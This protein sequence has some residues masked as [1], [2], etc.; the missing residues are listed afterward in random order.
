MKLGFCSQLLHKTWQLAAQSLLKA[1]FSLLS[2]PL[3]LHA[4][5]A[6]DPREES[7]QENG[8]TR[9]SFQCQHPPSWGLAFREKR[10]FLFM[11]A[12][13]GLKGKDPSCG[14]KKKS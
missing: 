11:F 1:F 8:L 10:D 2:L 3:P 6:W 9:K 5:H 14:L 4:H 7:E 13:T 12:W